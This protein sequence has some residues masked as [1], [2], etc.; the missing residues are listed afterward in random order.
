M[1][2]LKAA[3]ICAEQVSLAPRIFTAGNVRAADP[4]ITSS[5]YLLRDISFEAFQGDRIA[6]VG[7]SGAGKTSLLR[8][9][10][11][12]SEPTSGVI[13]LEN[14][15]L[16]QIPAVQLRQ[17]VV[18]VLQESKLLGMTVQQT[19]EYP[20]VLRQLEKKVIQE[21]VRYWSDR[22]HIPADWLNR[23]E[24]Q[25]SVGQ[26]QWV[27]IARAL[28]AEPKVL[29]LD[30]PTASLDLG[31]SDLLLRTLIEL[32]QGQGTAIVMANHQL[33]LAEQFGD[34]VLHLDHGLLQQDLSMQQMN[35]QALR[36]TI[37]QAEAHQ[38]DEWD[39]PSLL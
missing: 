20:L 22:L 16:H 12:L 19:L 14:Q 15:A 29:L 35:W 28:I 34:R 37:V 8:L 3:L 24:L 2:T 32:A 25:L 21:R 38:S 6:L 9:L 39:E 31:R 7:A 18:L 5:H 23:T 33:E 10:N 30:E 26:R 36:Q 17:Q 4:S 13:Y 11:R 1:H 27:A